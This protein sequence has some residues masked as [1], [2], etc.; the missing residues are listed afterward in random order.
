V[1]YCKTESCLRSVK[2]FRK[3]ITRTSTVFCRLSNPMEQRASS[4]ANSRSGNKN[5]PPCYGESEG[6]V[7]RSQEFATVSILIQMNPVNIFRLYLLQVGVGPPGFNAV[8]TCRQIS[9]FRRNKLSLS[10]GLKLQP[11]RPTATSSPPWDPQI[12]PIIS[13]RFSG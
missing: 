4:E 9:T 3:V 8:W 10:S 7:T 5:I 2:M 13:Y 1:G 6:P 11:R 12:S